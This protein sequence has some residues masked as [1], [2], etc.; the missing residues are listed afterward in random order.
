[1]PAF[2]IPIA[3][4]LAR[5]QRLQKRVQEHYEAYSRAMV[6]TRQRVLVEGHARKDAAELAARTG[7][8]RVVNFAGPERLVGSYVEVE[9]TAALPH[10]LRGRLADSVHRGTRVPVSEEQS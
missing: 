4:K 9:I 8:N 7:N 1:M 5:L 2:P 10:S 6:G 3:A